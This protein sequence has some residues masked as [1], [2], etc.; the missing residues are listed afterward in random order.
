MISKICI[1]TNIFPSKSETFVSLL[2]LELL[3]RGYDVS[4]ISL[5]NP[6]D[7]EQ[8][9]ISS[10]PNDLKNKFDSLKIFRSKY[11]RSLSKFIL[12]FV[13]IKYTLK[14]LYKKSFFYKLI[15]LIVQFKFNK[16]M[17]IV[18]DYDTLK[19]L[20][21]RTIIH[22]QYATLAFRY[23]TLVKYNLVDGDLKRFFSIRG[24]DISKYSERNIIDWNLLFTNSRKVFP[25]C[26]FFKNEL[27]KLGCRED[28]ISVVY[29]PIETSYY[30]SFHPPSNTELLFKI[31]SVGRM[32]EKKGFD[33][34]IKA[35]SLLKIKGIDFKWVFVGQGA[36]LESFKIKVEELELSD[37]V[38]FLGGLNSSETFKIIGDSNLLV[39]P[40]KRAQ[41]GDR[42]GIPN[43]LK[44]AMLL[45]LPVLSTYHS[46]IPELIG[47]DSFGYLVN[48]ND[49]SALVDMI[50]FILNN[51]KSEALLKRASTIDSVYNKFNKE[52]YINRMLTEY[53][54]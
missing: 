46:G 16:I 1:V 18:F 37:R 32:V 4:V 40:S 11:D 52:L 50:I 33:D 23:E 19:G 28:K 54:E 15:K 20:D 31:V 38:V 34:A 39:A 35:A 48:E 24:Y 17:E 25:V 5:Y 41:D 6:K 9:S 3:I 12:F 10:L 53:F 22:F 26:N 8:L 51:Y 47:K 29:S 27:I 13:T 7:K 36:L 44:E 43:V 2:V 42:E 14:L 49:P 21:D 45:G 30:S